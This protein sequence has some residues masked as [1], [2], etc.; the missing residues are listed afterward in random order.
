M[1]EIILFSGEGCSGCDEVKKHIKNPSK[2]KIVD[3]TKD[4]DYAR[5]AIE[6]G[7]NAIPSIAIK[8]EEGIKKCELK[9]EGNIVKAKC[10]DKEIIL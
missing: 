8:T 7:I 9:L 3:V 6:N 10:K 4:E 1:S 5:L 2:L